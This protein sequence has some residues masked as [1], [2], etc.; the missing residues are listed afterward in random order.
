MKFSW[1]KLYLISIFII[2]LNILVGCK[3]HQHTLGDYTY[4]AYLH[5]QE[6][7]DC[8]EKVNHVY[9]TYGTWKIEKE[10]TE[11]EEGLRRQTCSACGFS[12][13]ETISV[14]AHQHVYGAW[15]F[16]VLPSLSNPG[17]IKRAC[18]IDITHIQEVEIPVLNRTFYRYKILREPN[19]GEKGIEIYSFSRDGQTLE[20]RQ[21]MPLT[22]H[23]YAPS[24]TSNSLGHWHQAICEHSTLRKD[25]EA[26]TYRNG[27]CTVCGW[28]ETV[29]EHI[30]EYGAWELIASPTLESLGEIKRIC[31]T[32][33]THVEYKELPLLNDKDYE[34]EIL[35]ESSCSERGKA[36]YTITVEEQT[37]TFLVEL[38]LSDHSYGVEWVTDNRYHW[39]QATCIHTEEKQDY[40]LHEFE[41]GRCKI[42]DYIGYSEGLVYEMNEDHISYRIIGLGSF[43]EKEL[44]IPGAY[45]GLP[46]TKISSAAF[47]NCTFI[48][49]IRVLDGVLEFGDSA[50]MGC[51]SLQSIELP[52]TLKIVG[53][54]CFEGCSSL[55]SFLGND[56]LEQVKDS[57]FKNCTQLSS[58]SL[59]N[60]LMLLGKFI[61][62]GCST[63][64]FKAYDNGIY[65]G[66]QE[67]PYL[68]FYKAN[69][70]LIRTCKLHESTKFI[71][72]SAFNECRSL[73]SIVIP[74][75]VTTIG[76]NSFY[77]CVSLEY[78]I[79]GQGVTR[80]EQAAFGK[81]TA[82]KSLFY[83]GNKEEFQKI[84]IGTN[85]SFEH[86]Y[87]YAE[88][89]SSSEEWTFDENDKPV[90]FQ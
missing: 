36:Q 40:A 29:Q 73:K 12:K 38:S 86:I 55:K 33:D 67:N 19:C 78:I 71:A 89:P 42:C 11:T 32:N 74:D 20:I 88:D 48:E 54:S 60:S 17:K 13:T 10:P 9:H 45:Q 49:K 59:P 44:V 77:Y 52:G 70:T 15:E 83:M 61:L 22:E 37:F 72:D 90:P 69:D 80:I 81:C 84:E 65:L 31:K 50:F 5:W 58:I 87:F 18:S 3:S 56:G 27:F 53:S 68:I 51:T 39:H 30:C 25:F 7:M 75:Q 14:T 64:E 4:D 85:N 82:L 47:K 46:V 8:H 66:N 63:I 1:K 79:L 2:V 21:D 6:C 35:E 24:W 57:A 41:N 26:H 16:E 23:S 28:E 34:Y 62:D 43:S 76:S